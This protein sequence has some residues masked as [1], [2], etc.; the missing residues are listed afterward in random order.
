[1]TGPS[2]R[3]GSIRRSRQE[4]PL[5]PGLIRSGSYRSVVVVAVGMWATRAHRSSGCTRPSGRELSKAG[6]KQNDVLVRY[7]GK[8][9]DLNMRGLN[10]NLRMNYKVGQKLPLT[11]MRGGKRIEVEVQLVAND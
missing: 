11:V 7:G 2:G 10:A 3:F 9:I 6:I 1:M 5:V 4:R 8:P